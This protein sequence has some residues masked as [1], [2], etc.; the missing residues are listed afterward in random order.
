[1]LHWLCGWKEALCSSYAGAWIQW[2]ESAS[3][4]TAQH[5]ENIYRLTKCGQGVWFPISEKKSIRKLT[6]ICSQRGMFI[7][8]LFQRLTQT[9]FLFKWVPPLWYHLTSCYRQNYPLLNRFEINCLEGW[10]VC[11]FVTSPTCLWQSYFLKK[12]MF[13][14]QFRQVN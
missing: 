3:S 1:M 2:E 8:K 6:T 9:S 13:N 5:V 10:V 11:G 14:S 12:S 4:C 7:F